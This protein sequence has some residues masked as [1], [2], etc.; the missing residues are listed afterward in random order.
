MPGPCA[1]LVK[2]LAV[3]AQ[4]LI[5]AGASHTLPSGTEGR[6]DSAR[7]LARRLRSFAVL[8]VFQQFELA[9]GLALPDGEIEL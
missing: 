7:Q 3:G 6:G 8:R 1:H 4:A 2:A 5:D 9:Q